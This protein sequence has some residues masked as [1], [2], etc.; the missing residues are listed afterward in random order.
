VATRIP[1]FPLPLVLLP[2]MRMP[3]H[4]FE[5]R[6]RQMVHDCMAGDRTFG[7][8]YRAEGAADDSLSPGSVG[9]RAIIDDVEPLPDGRANILVNGGERF[10]LRRYVDDERPYP[11]VEVQTV[12]DTEEPVAQVTALTLR[13]RELFAEAAI[14]SR[15]LA[16]DLAP[17]PVLPP[18]PEQIAFSAAASIDL[19]AGERQ[20]LL[21]SPSP[22]GRMRQIISLLTSSLPALR[23]RA[24]VHQ[25]ASRNGHGPRSPT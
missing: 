7:L 9:C 3:L 8:I 17:V 15:V 23:E 11:V 14:A 5:P 19:D 10:A 4:I 24:S 22:S 25:R 18:D 2:G 1:L 20:R 12:T 16:D 13:L 6:Y 21:E